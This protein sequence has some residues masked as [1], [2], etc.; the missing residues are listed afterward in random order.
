MINP[1]QKISPRKSQIGDY[2][3][4][5]QNLQYTSFPA[6][7]VDVV[8]D[9]SHPLYKNDTSIGLIAFR[10]YK[11]SIIRY[12]KPLNIRN[13]TIPYKNEIVSIIMSNS[14]DAGTLDESM[15]YY[16][17]SDISIWGLINMNFSPYSTR[18][19]TLDENRTLDKYN[20]SSA[21]IPLTS[22]DNNFTPDLL[23][24]KQILKRQSV[25]VYEGDSIYQGRWGNSIHFSSTIL[26]KKNE[27]S[28]KGEIGDPIIIIRSDRSE[29][30]FGEMIDEQIEKMD[31]AIYICSNHS[32]PLKQSGY[33]DS[34]KKIGASKYESLNSYLGSQIIFISNRIVLKAKN[35][36]IIMISDKQFSVRAGDDMH[37]SSDKNVY[38]RGKNNYIGEARYKAVN[39][40]KLFT[41]L[42]ELITAIEAISVTVLSPAPGTPTSPPLNI[43]AFESIRLRL[44]DFLSSNVYI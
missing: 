25:R 8:V 26:D 29:K 43:P 4:S 16:Y 32:L 44:K 35:N 21:G 27:W 34:Y 7:V 39:G 18:D 5:L 14:V 42:N 19:Y 1:I 30:E 2:N 38:L 33:S 23:Y 24:T 6:E 17:S 22:N 9:D 31:S 11:S 12:A 40:E 36:D 20:D 41:L 28:N 37:L 13:Y 10:T 3:K 15:S